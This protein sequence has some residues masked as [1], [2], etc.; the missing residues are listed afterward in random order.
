MRLSIYTYNGT[1]INDGT[2]Y[3]AYWP[4]GSIFLQQPVEAVEV[5]R[6]G[7]VPSYAGKKI[8]A[9]YNLPIVINMKGTISTQIDTLKKLFN[10]HDQTQ[11]QLICK[12]GANSDKQ[13]YLMVTPISEASVEGNS[14]TFNLSVS[15]PIWQ[16]V[17]PTTA[18]WAVTATGQTKDLV[19]AGNY[20]CKPVFTITPTA[21]D[22]TFGWKKF[23][24][25]RNRTAT[26]LNSYH[27]EMTI[28]GSWDTS[29]LINFTTNHAHVNVG[30]GINDT[31]TTIPYGSETGTLPSVGFGMIQTEQISWTGKSGGNL[32][33]VTRGIGGTTA[34]SHADT[35]QINQSK[36]QANGDDIR[37]YE[38]GTEIKRWL[39][40]INTATTK[41]W[42]NINLKP[43]Q[44]FY[45]GTAI[46]G[47]GAI[48]TITFNVYSSLAI[49]TIPASGTMLIGNELFSYTGVNI[50]SLQLTGVTRA[51][52]GTSM[53]S[54][55]AL[56]M[57][58]F[59]EHQY[60]L[61]Y[62]NTTLA[63]YDTDDTNKPIINLSTSTN[64]S[65][66]YAEFRDT[67]GLRSGS[68]SPTIVSS[69]N[70]TD[71]THQSAP[72]TGSRTAIADPAT[73]MGLGLAASIKNNA[74]QAETGTVAWS[75][76]VPTGVNTATLSGEK[77]RY[78]TNWPGLALLQCSQNGTYWYNA[79][80]TEVT[81]ASLQTWTA[82][83]AHNAV[84]L[85]AVMYYLRWILSGTLG[86]TASNAAYIS[87]T[88]VT[89][90]RTGNLEPTGT[91]GAEQTNY[92]MSAKI[93]NNTTGEWIQ[94]NIGMVLNG[95]VTVD[96]LNKTVVD[97]LG[98]NQ[99]GGITYST[100]RI[101][102]LNLIAAVT[103]TLQFD[104][105]GTSGVTVAISY[106]QK[107]S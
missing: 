87:A 52:N 67:A 36:M 42:A 105:G 47:S 90:V 74:W 37:L 17:T 49:K 62:G 78:T 57:C 18:S 64:L 89:L 23:I 92:M 45:L 41:V 97:S 16:E 24:T 33:G 9:G 15:D 27:F 88:D 50:K 19:V 71:I 75:L 35:T 54:H 29:A 1:A 28:G 4:T 107:N 7:N 43:K 95:S 51:I 84:A 76:Y 106:V 93:T 99:I 102:W 91:F 82:L 101:D 44:E 11:H 72:Y 20:A 48:T 10:T 6:A 30:G 56:V 59:I 104:G 61:Y 63:S 79:W 58:Y 77:Y 34:A 12:D 55:A 103:N 70:I 100:S 26:Q 94:L 83:T 96:C 2:Y 86:A 25:L 81:P 69:M 22:G 53:A 66:V 8:S 98:V 3:Q 14:I 32:T 65:W 80:A 31:V 60:W 39:D 13:W 38:D 5:E 46:A 85:P 68:W 40:G 73:E 21:G